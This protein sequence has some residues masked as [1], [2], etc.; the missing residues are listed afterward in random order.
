MHGSRLAISTILI[1]TSNRPAAL[2]RCLR[3]LIS[4]ASAFQHSVRIAICDG[5]Q[6]LE[7][8]EQNR[9]VI[10][11]CRSESPFPIFRVGVEH[12]QTIVKDLVYL[13]V[14][15]SVAQFGICGSIHDG[16]VTTG[17]Q[18]NLLLLLGGADPFLSVDDDVQFTFAVGNQF[19]PPH[20]GEGALM[21][22][23]K[24]PVQHRFFESHEVASGFARYAIDFIGEHESLLGTTRQFEDANRES[25]FEELNTGPAT[26]T[27][28]S[29]VAMTISGIIGDC[30]WGSP[31][32]FLFLDDESWDRLTASNATYIRGISSREIA[33]F[34]PFY[35]ISESPGELMTTAFAGLGRLLEHPFLPIGRG[36]D[37]LFGNMLKRLRPE[38][39]FAHLPHMILHT[40]CNPRKFWRNE[41]ARSAPTIHLY[42]AI[43]NLIASVAKNE[44][45]V[46]TQSLDNY[47]QHLQQL[48][49]FSDASL[50]EVLGTIYRAAKDREREFLEFRLAQA[51]DKGGSQFEDIKRYLERLAIASKDGASAI[52][53][54][55]L[56]R[57][58]PSTAYLRLREILQQFGELLEEWPRMR[59]AAVHLRDGWLALDS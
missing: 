39:H 55:L 54:E 17:A 37:V 7:T 30:G 52:P 28:T 5:S 32:K 31:S 21:R 11:N 49:A 10:K 16:L 56:Y 53:I 13:G 4:N 45:A 3:G 59:R 40:P 58:D 47:A 51:V 35:A 15:P 22:F 29:E 46:D 2:E 42:A 23:E 48:A 38:V 9:Q 26:V 1:P 27:P 36:Q 24:P 8:R 19:I 20:R 41:V 50:R 43:D 14:R 12:A 44:L 6:S 25:R 33:R 57:H 18:R 34:V